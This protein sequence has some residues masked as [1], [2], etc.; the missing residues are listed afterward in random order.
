MMMMIWS[1]AGQ[2]RI[3]GIIIGQG[4]GCRTS[5]R[6]QEREEMLIGVPQSG[7]VAWAAWRSGAGSRT[8]GDGHAAD[9]MY[10]GCAMEGRALRRAEFRKVNRFPSK[11]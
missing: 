10:G 8:N 5:G 7:N 9:K 1:L 2:V 4:I 6:L 3:Q 11:L